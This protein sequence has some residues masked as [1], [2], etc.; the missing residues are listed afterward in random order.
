MACTTALAVAPL[1]PCAPG[2]PLAFMMN[3]P[4]SLTGASALVTVK[5][6][7]LTVAVVLLLNLLVAIVRRWRERLD[8]SVAEPQPAWRG[9]QA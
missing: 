7:V 5:V 2:V 1:P 6:F 9:V 4:A 3:R 8:G